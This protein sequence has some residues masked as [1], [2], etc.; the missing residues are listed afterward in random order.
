MYDNIVIVEQP[1]VE[2]KEEQQIEQ[3]KVEESKIEQQSEE[4]I[5]EKPEEA[6]SE[7]VKSEEKQS[8][9]KEER[10]ETVDIRNK[11]VDGKIIVTKIKRVYK[12]GILRGEYYMN[13]E[14][15]L[16]RDNNSYG[17][18]GPAFVRYAEDGKT[19]TYEAWY[20]DNKSHRDDGLPATQSYFVDDKY[21]KRLAEESWY[22]RNMRHR[23]GDFPSYVR[24]N[25]EGKIMLQIWHKLGKVHRNPINGPASI[26]Y[27][28][29][30]TIDES[31]YKYVTNTDV[32]PVDPKVKELCNSIVNLTA[33]ELDKYIKLID[34][35]KK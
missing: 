8:E 1:K 2:K 29:D 35:I 26:E 30:G 17:G 31:K 12:N 25:K 27:N 14:D 13:A 9:K 32:I 28:E 18:D 21:R 5:E 3:P 16:H 33:E 11:L 7:E 22:V 4:K 23:D 10:F 20:Q 6:K 34:L 19:S 24:Y 15:Q